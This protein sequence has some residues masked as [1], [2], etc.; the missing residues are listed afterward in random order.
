MLKNNLQKAGVILS[1]L[2][3]W[4]FICYAFL[5]DDLFKLHHIQLDFS[6]DGMKNYFA[7]AYQYKQ[8]KVMW[9]EGMQ[10]PYGDLLLYADGQSAFVAIL[11]G[12]KKIG[13]DFSGYELLMVQ[14]AALFTTVSYTHLTLPTKRIV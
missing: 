8:E 7:V 11:V 5:K 3:A 2:I 4:F 13:I 6:G 10:Y 1:Y 14:S 9:F 12:L